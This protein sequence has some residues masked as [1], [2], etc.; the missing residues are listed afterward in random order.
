MDPSSPEAKEVDFFSQHE[1]TIPDREPQ[2]NIPV[3]DNQKLSSD[4]V[5]IENGS[6][7]RKVDNEPVGNGEGPN[8]DLALSMSPTEASAKAEPRKSLIG[9]KKAGAKKGVGRY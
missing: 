1:D 7:T 2:S 4:P 9:A 8:V 5:P 3:E 6:L